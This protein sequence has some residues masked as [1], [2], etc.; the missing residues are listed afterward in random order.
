MHSQVRTW[1]IAAGAAVLCATAASAQYSE[2]FESYPASG[3]GTTFT[4]GGAPNS[5]GWRQWD[6]AFNEDTKA[7]T[8]AGGP[9]AAH[10]GTQYI[11]TQLLGDTIHEFTTF[12]SGHWDISA[13]VYVPGPSSPNPAMDTQWLVLLQDYNDFGPYLWATQIVFDPLVGTV[14]AD[15]GVGLISCAPQ[16]GNGTLLTFDAW[17]Q[18]V[19]DVDVAT[20]TAICFYD[21]FQIGEPFRWSQGPFGQNGGAGQPCPAPTFGTPAIDC[22]DL[23]ANSSAIAN[24]FAYWDDVAIQPDGGSN[25]PMTYCTVGTSAAGCNPAIAF[26]GTPSASAPSG[27]TLSVANIDANRNGIFFYGV[28]DTNFTPV[29]WGPGGT[30]FLCVKAPTQRMGTMSSGGTSGC[31]GSFAQDWNAFRAANPA[32]LGSPFMAGDSFDAQLWYRDPPSPKTTILSDAV[33]FI[34]AP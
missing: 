18:V 21:G 10:G 17:K 2:N 13:W 31:T 23:Y 6:S 25:Q 26:S 30:S 28:T 12:T 4:P 29:Q 32:A 15:N 3:A 20:D 34:L 11:G 8:T 9:V 14:Q 24:S 22:I 16:Y 19:V 33:R 27:F 5:G 1:A 7:F